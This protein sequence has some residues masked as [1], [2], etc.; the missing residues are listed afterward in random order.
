MRRP[1]CGRTTRRTG[2]PDR[3]RHPEDAEISTS[4]RWPDLSDLSHELIRAAASDI[5]QITKKHVHLRG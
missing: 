5:E 3:H 2:R 4:W 1:G